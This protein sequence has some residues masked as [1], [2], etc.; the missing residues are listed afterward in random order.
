MSL[1]GSIL[2]G[3]AGGSR[4]YS[5][6]GWNRGSSYARRPRGFGYGRSR[7][8][9]GG[10]LSGSLGRMAI[11]GLTAYGMRRFF[12]GRRPYGY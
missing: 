11:G 5:A 1:L 2:G 12:G 6:G 10:F 7:A 3:L 9:S 8:S 4:G